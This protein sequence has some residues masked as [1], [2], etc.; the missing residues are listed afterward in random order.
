MSGHSHWHSIKYQ[1]GVAD[2]K[3]SKVFSKITGQIMVTAKE[4]GGDPN[5]NSKLR[6][7]IDQAKAINMPS[8]NIERAIKRGVGDLGGT[9]LEPVIFE[10]Y[11]PGGIALIVEGITDN[12]NRTVSEIKQILGQNNGKFAETG[13]V[14][15]L[16]ERKGVISLRTTNKYESAS[17]EELELKLI[18]AGVE[19]FHWHNNTI[20]VYTKA[21]DL[22][23]AKKN[24]EDQEI[25]IESAS[26]DWVAKEGIQIKEKD[27]EAAQKLFDAL[28]ELE[29][30]QEIYSNLK[31]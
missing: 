28:D 8:D 13:S 23:R 4:G 26:L 16:F 3:K 18:E 29:A 2:A 14:K 7:A 24:L 30:V 15:W 20:D 19:D 17:R 22:E 21:E 5:K 11:G 10:A 1:K 6:L 31:I 27:R 9:K 25:K 12:K